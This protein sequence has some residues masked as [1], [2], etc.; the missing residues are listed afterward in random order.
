MPLA[1]KQ[2]K[3][4]QLSVMPDTVCRLRGTAM[5]APG[6]VYIGTYYYV[7][8]WLQGETKDNAMLTAFLFGLGFTAPQLQVLMYKQAHSR[9][10]HALR[11]V[12]CM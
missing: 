12:D 1:G 5:D 6:L 10:V 2:L 7:L 11:T 3:H 4:K 8:A 9:D